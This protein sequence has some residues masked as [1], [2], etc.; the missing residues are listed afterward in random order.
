VNIDCDGGT[1][2]GAADIARVDIID[3]PSLGCETVI[4]Q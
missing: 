1:S 4:F 3:P 2:P